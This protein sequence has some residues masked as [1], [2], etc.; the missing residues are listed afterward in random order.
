MAEL[1]EHLEAPTNI[2]MKLKTI[3]LYEI[4]GK[5]FK[6]LRDAK[7]HI[8]NE[9]GKILDSIHYTTPPFNLT[10]KDA[11]VIHETIIKNKK[12][13]V[14]LLTVEVEREIVND[15]DYRTDNLLDMKL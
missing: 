13:L 11:L 2:K 4:D 6:H 10:P 7:V 1:K 8:E 15:S 5:Q 3:E 12:R 9:I 14:E